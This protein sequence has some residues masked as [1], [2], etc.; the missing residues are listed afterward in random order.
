MNNLVLKEGE[1]TAK[2]A[3][4]NLVFLATIKAIAGV[5]TGMSVIIADAV[6]T[7][8]DTLGLFASYIGLKLSRKGADDEFEYGYYK[9]ETFAA[10]IIS[11]SILY[12]GGVILFNGINNLEQ[13]DVGAYRPL[14][15][16][17]T[18]ISIFLSHKLAQK[19]KASAEKVNSLSLLASSKDKKMDMLAGIIVLVSIIANYQGIPYVEGIVTIIIALLIIKEGLFSS[20]ESLFFLLDYWNNP[21]L[22]NKIKRV[23]KNQKGVIKE[24]KKI[25]LRR[26]GTFIFGEAFVDINPFVGIEDVREELEIIQEKIKDLNPYIKDFSVYTHIPKSI[27][28]KVAVPVKKGR[29][30]N[31]EVANTLNETIGYVF[32]ELKKNKPTKSYFKSL[33]AADKDPVKL[34]R[35]FKKEKINILIDNKLSSLIYYNLRRTNHVLIYPNFADVSKVNDTIKLLLID[36]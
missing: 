13:S 17:T 35:Y 15:I 28:T 22:L 24:I 14:A 30:M 4:L 5:V 25:R 26:A 23:F 11:L 7:L 31:A 27:K 20:K 6:S 16:T 10:L 21:I 12:I 29:T 32:V 1:E 19:L 8:T 36:S 9:F 18:V 2:K 3:I 34:A 33:K